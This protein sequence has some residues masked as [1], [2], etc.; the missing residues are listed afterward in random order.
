MRRV[1]VRSEDVEAFD[2]LSVDDLSSWEDDGP[3][4]PLL[5]TVNYPVHLKVSIIKNTAPYIVPS[6]EITSLTRPCSIRRWRDS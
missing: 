2:K 5:D 6:S 4:T 1:E 3:N